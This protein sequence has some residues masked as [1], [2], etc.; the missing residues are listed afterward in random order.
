MVMSI[1]TLQYYTLSH[2]EYIPKAMTN[3]VIIKLCSNLQ[4]ENANIYTPSAVTLASSFVYDESPAII[5][6]AILEGVLK[7]FLNLLYTGGCSD[8]LHKILWGLS[9]ITGGYVS[10]VSAFIQEEELV[11]RVLILIK[12]KSFIVKCEALYTIVN[13]I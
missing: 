9:N 2:T 4:S 13:A 5:D 8:L 3:Q 12:N 6:K 7:H 10:H 1:M 11:Q